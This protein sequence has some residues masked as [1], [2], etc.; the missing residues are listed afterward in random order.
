MHETSICTALLA[1]VERVAHAQ[2]STAVTRVR[3]AVGPLSGIDAHLLR[4]AYELARAGTIAAEAPLE[5]EQTVIEIVCK[6]CDART[7]AEPQR[8]VCGE[9]GHWQTQLVSGDELVLSQVELLA[10]L[11]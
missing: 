6:R 4:R 1:E 9:C 5:I 7:R 11:H 3:I 10:G 2:N 8:I